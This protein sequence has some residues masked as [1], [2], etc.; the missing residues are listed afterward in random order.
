VVAKL[1]DRLAVR[2]QTTNTVHMERLNLKEL[3]EVEVKEQYRVELSNRFAALEH[4]YTE[5]NVNRAWETIGENKKISTK[6]SLSCNELKKH[7][8]W[9]DEG[10]SKL[11]NRRKQAKLQWFRIQVK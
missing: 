2:K 8:P 10:C 4:L 3:N 11:L 1:R 9:F 5:V 6:E 7:K